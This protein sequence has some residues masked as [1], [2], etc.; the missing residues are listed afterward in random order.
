MRSFALLGVLCLFTM[1]SAGCG[2]TVG[3]DAAAPRMRQ[4]ADA[5]KGTEAA[6]AWREGY[7]PL[8]DAVRLPDGAF[9]NEE[10]KLAYL[11]RNFTLRRALPGSTAR[12]GH[13][14]WTSGASLPATIMTARQAYETLDRDDDGPGAGDAPLTV[15]EA[16]LGTTTLNT[17]RGP[18]RVPAWL[19]TLDGYD[20]P[21]KRVAVAPSKPP[22]APVRSLSEGTDSGS[23]LYGLRSVA[24]DGRSVTVGAAHGACDD[25]P[26]VDVLETR[27]SVVL[28]GGVRGV[29]DGPCT[30]Q[31]LVDPVTVRLD[32]PLGGRLLL[33]AFTG[34]PVTMTG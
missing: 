5:W 7:Y 20:T 18:A 30:M 19:F 9:H 15:T 22:R 32:R 23:P 14:R 29:D 31:L 25:G 26:T 34:A 1:G 21:L 10:D 16:V 27:D 11:H 4:V 6:R 13:I 33:D 12:H 24:E 2:T 8:E 17:S 3:A 28:S